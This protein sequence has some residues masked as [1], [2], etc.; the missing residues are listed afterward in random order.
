LASGK[1]LQFFLKNKLIVHL[2][3]FPTSLKL[4]LQRGTTFSFE[5]TKTSP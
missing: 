2:I 5:T 4:Q 1:N 3:N